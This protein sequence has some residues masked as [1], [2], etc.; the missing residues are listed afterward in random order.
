[1][2]AI[3]RLMTYSILSTLMALQAKT[4]EQHNTL[5]ALALLAFLQAMDLAGENLK[6]GKD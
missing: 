1:M 2:N 5:K 4:R 3:N 6:V